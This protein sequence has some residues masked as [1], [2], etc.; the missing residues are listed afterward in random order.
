MKNRLLVV[1]FFS[2]LLAGCTHRVKVDP[3]KVEPIHVTMDIHL[4]VDRELE[5]FFSFEQAIEEEL[6]ERAE[7]GSTGTK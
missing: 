1:A 3:I 4:K 6:E 5:D 7:T 2:L